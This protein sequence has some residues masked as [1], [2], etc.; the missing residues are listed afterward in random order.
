MDAERERLEAAA[1][2]VMVPDQEAREAGPERVRLVAGILAGP[3][4]VRTATE[5]KVGRRG[6]QPFEAASTKVS[7]WRFGLGAFLS[8]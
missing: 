4:G 8:T 2:M 5:V 7:S 3:P 6:S 1:R